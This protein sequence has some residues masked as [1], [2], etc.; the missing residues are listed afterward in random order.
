MGKV[1]LP[2]LVCVCV[3]CKG[4]VNIV[5]IMEVELNAMLSVCVVSFVPYVCLWI[6]CGKAEEDTG[7]PIIIP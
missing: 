1:H 3:C 6:R 7:Q 2:F 5:C 4:G